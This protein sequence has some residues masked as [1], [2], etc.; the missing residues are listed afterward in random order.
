[1]RS[2][3]PASEYFHSKTI[4]IASRL[5]F[6]G[7]DLCIRPHNLPGATGIKM[8]GIKPVAFLAT[9][10]H[11]SSRPERSGVEWRDL[12]LSLLVSNADLSTPLRSGR[13]DNTIVRMS[14]VFQWDT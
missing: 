3:S 1:M 11:L 10:K 12:S 2:Q 8:G 9:A 5:Q 6:V 4:V 13:D 14:Q 7:L